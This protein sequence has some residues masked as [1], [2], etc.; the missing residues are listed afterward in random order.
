MKDLWRGE[1]NWPKVQSQ[2]GTEK[3]IGI[4]RLLG[5]KGRGRGKLPLRRKARSGMGSHVGGG[6]GTKHS[7]LPRHRA[8]QRGQPCCKHPQE[9][10]GRAG[11]LP[12]FL[13]GQ[14]LAPS[15]P[16]CCVSCLCVE[17]H[18]SPP[19]RQIRDSPSRPEQAGTLQSLTQQGLL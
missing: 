1:A 9:G 16:Q 14:G 7:C 13:Q 6:K 8:A 15:F 4:R 5:A 18:M 12:L 2:P 3:V 10:D 19:W 17:P 11:I